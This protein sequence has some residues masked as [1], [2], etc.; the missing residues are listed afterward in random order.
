MKN[1]FY[2]DPK[3]SELSINSYSKLINR[4]REW[5]Q[6]FDALPDLIAIID[7][8]HRIKKVNK[9]MADHLNGKPEDFIGM[10]CFSLVHG[11]NEPPNFCPYSELLEDLQPHVKEVPIE[12]LQGDF[13]VSVSPIFNNDGQLTGSVHVVQDI[14]HRKKTEELSRLLAAIVESSDDAIIGKDLDGKITSWNKAAQK[15]YD[16]SSEE[17]IG[18]SI[19]ILL[20]SKHA[21]DL[22]QIMSKI[23]NGESIKQYDT[24]RRRKD[25]KLID[26]SLF[27]SPILDSDGT[28]IG[29]STTAHDIT[30]RKRMEEKLKESEEK[31][32][33]VFNNAN[34]AMFLHKLKNRKP[35]NFLE[36]N[37]VACQILGYSREELKQLSPKDIDSPETI[38]RTPQIVQKLFKDSKTTFEA[39]QLTKHGEKLPVEINAHLFTLKG[40]EYILSIARDIRERKNAEEALKNSE[41]KYRKIFENVQD[42]FYQTDNNGKII[43]IS[44]SIERYSGHKPEE[45]LGKPAEMVYLNPKDRNILL[46][47]IQEREEVVDY[48]LKLKTKSNNMLYVSVNAHFLFDSNNN[49]IGIEGS[50]RDITERKNIEIQLQKSLEEKE[51]LLKEI[52]HRV[53]NNLMIISNLLNIQS[54]YIKDKTSQDIFKESQNRARSMALIHERLYRSTDLKSINFGDYIQTL[55]T[56]LFQTYIPNPNHVNLNLNVEEE[57]VDINTTVPLGLIVNELITNSMKHAFKDGRK[58]EINIEFHKNEE[59]ILIVS[60]TGIG[61][62]DDLDYKNTDSLG[63][64]L[65]NGLVGQINGQIELDRSHGTKF[66]IT[67]KELEYKE[68]NSKGF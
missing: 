55:A 31:Y 6:A 67:F 18:N 10:K 39:V 1:Q 66:K 33:E 63:L 17:I 65:V 24:I 22:D 28:V 19:S 29:D 30:E 59:F 27:I 40:E 58:G 13:I 62:P 4:N 34:D 3:K 68:R 42:V 60:D 46:T 11:T 5:E 36:V 9:V 35:G 53:K 41:I 56:E 43:E 14:T 61:F 23:K 8:N 12:R 52:H 57:M 51:M 25:G 26:V 21:D 48:E 64:Q 15:M 45:L 20:P 16:Y 54:G 2:Q 49:P 50:L 47:E 32:R 37:D 38:A 7:V 44:P